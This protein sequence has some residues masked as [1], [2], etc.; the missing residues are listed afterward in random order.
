MS[1]C[2]K[3]NVTPSLSSTVSCLLC[4]FLSNGSSLFLPS[5]YDFQFLQDLPPEIV[6][7]LDTPIVSVM[8]TA[9]IRHSLKQFCTFAR[10]IEVRSL[11]HKRLRHARDPRSRSFHG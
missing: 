2:T 4:L 6:V 8:H 11:L 3:C 9:Q 10:Q 1:S 5:F 7:F